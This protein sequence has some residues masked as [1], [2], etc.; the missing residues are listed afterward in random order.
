[1]EGAEAGS[2]Q[3]QAGNQETDPIKRRRL[4]SKSTVS[5]ISVVDWM[6]LGACSEMESTD[7]CPMKRPNSQGMSGY[8]MLVEPMKRYSEIS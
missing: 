7:N 1:M 8:A 3:M 5:H 6:R 2:K 4:E